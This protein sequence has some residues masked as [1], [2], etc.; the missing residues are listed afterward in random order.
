MSRRRQRQK[1]IS[2]INV[3]PYLDVLLVLLVIFMITTP[4]FSQ[5]VIDLP[6]VGE[7]GMPG[8]EDVALEVYYE[9]R[10]RNPYRL[11][12]HKAGSETVQLSLHELLRELKKKEVLYKNPTIILS[13]QKELSYEEVIGLLGNLRDAGYGNINLAVEN[14]GQ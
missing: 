3:V 8:A 6:S 5:G 10:D 13:A 11:K 9:K 7:Q 12:D 2:N 4:L 14:P 1:P